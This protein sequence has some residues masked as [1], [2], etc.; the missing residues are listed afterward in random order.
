MAAEAQEALFRVVA[1][2]MHLGNLEFEPL[3]IAVSAEIPRILHNCQLIYLIQLLACG[4][5]ISSGIA[6]AGARPAAIHLY[7]YLQLY[8]CVLRDKRSLLL[9]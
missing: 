2:V 8:S 5:H 9:A 1:A 7:T 4:E 3:H 6:T